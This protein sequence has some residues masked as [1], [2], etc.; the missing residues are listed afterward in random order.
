MQLPL[1]EGLLLDASAS[2]GPV[3]A[4]D[5]ADSESASRWSALAPAASMAGATSAFA[6]PL[7]VGAIRAGV[8]GLY[9][10]RPGPAR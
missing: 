4:S 9:R 6:F 3:L 1:G 8:R 10:A 7:V 5:L 2:S